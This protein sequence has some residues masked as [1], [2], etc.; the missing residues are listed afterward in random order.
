MGLAASRT[1]VAGVGWLCW[2]MLGVG[3]GLDAGGGEEVILVTECYVTLGDGLVC[4]PKA[5]FVMCMRV[6][7]MCM[8]SCLPYGVYCG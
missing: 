4:C 3:D 2:H 5:T 8:S 1:A 7:W 6:P